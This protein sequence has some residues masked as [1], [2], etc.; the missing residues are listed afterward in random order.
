MLPLLRI[1]VEHVSQRINVICIQRHRS[2]R[3]ASGERDPKPRGGYAKN[4]EIDILYVGFIAIHQLRAKLLIA[5]LVEWH[6]CLLP[7]KIHLPC[8]QYWSFE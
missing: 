2:I 6:Y 3:L 7:L 1:E 8:Q 5:F 4:I